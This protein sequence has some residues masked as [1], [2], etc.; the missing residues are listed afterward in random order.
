M[1]QKGQ[2]SSN[3]N[4]PATPL[5]SLFSK[6][7][8]VN[9]VLYHSIFLFLNILILAARV[10]FAKYLAQVVEPEIARTV[11][12]QGTSEQSTIG[13]GTGS[14]GKRDTRGSENGSG[15]RRLGSAVMGPDGEEEISNILRADDLERAEESVTATDEQN[16]SHKTLDGECHAVEANRTAVGVAKTSAGSPVFF[17]DN[18]VL[19]EASQDTTIF[20]DDSASIAGTEVKREFSE[21]AGILQKESNQEHSQLYIQPKEIGSRNSI[22]AQNTLSSVVTKPPPKAI[23]TTT[24]IH[25][26]SNRRRRKTRRSPHINLAKSIKASIL[27]LSWLAIG[28]TVY[29]SFSVFHLI[30]ILFLGEPPPFYF[31]NFLLSFWWPAA[32]ATGVFSV[33]LIQNRRGFRELKREIEDERREAKSA[34]RNAGRYRTEEQEL[35]SDGSTRWRSRQRVRRAESTRPQTPTFGNLDDR[36]QNGGHGDAGYNLW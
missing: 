19:E 27:T 32:F 6:L 16:P 21:Q 29:L 22:P 1:T 20:H 26:D 25:I 8:I 15:R 11:L 24:N 34:A 17:R 3:S 2:R 36:T 33:V 9:Q 4:L 12:S 35:R 23:T 31:I 28:T 10:R 14:I 13:S 30:M 7:I 5:E 18:R